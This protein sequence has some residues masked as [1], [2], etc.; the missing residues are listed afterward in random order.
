MVTWIL[1]ITLSPK[2]Q[3]IVQEHMETAC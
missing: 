2:L 3:E 1:G